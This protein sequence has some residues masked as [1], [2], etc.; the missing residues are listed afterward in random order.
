MI[1]FFFSRKRFKIEGAGEIVQ[2]VKSWPWRPW[3]DP[4]KL[5]IKGKKKD[6]QK[7]YVKVDVGDGMPIIPAL[8]KQTIGSLASQS[9][10]I[11]SSRVS[12]RLSKPDNLERNWGK[13]PISTSGICM[14]MHT[15][16]HTPHKKTGNGIF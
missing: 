13:Y 2:F 10:Q 3:F 9:S 11:Y 8:R 7:L 1:F 16:A 6:L 4:H 5:Y 14:Y 12:E 15:K